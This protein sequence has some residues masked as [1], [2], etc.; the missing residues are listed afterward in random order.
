[1]AYC[2]AMRK[3]STIPGIMTLI[4][5]AVLFSIALPASYDAGLSLFMF[6]VVT[7]FTIVGII[8]GISVGKKMAYTIHDRELMAARLTGKG[9]ITGTFGVA[10]D[11]S[12]LIG[13]I[14]IVGWTVFTLLLSFLEGA[15]VDSILMGYVRWLSI[16]AM[17]TLITGSYLLFRA[18][19]SA[20]HEMLSF[21]GKRAEMPAGMVEMMENRV[22]Y[23]ETQVINMPEKGFRMA[24]EVM[25][26]VEEAIH[27]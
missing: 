8:S 7:I 21:W 11:I 18:R 15:V 12:L 20:K 6:T 3:I 2:D 13:A 1:M 9:T 5:S 19:S 27:R 22:D 26:T 25:D 16:L 23:V 24:T 10:A 14:F 17:V 4:F